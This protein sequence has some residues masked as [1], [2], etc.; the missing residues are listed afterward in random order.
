VAKADIIIVGLHKAPN[1]PPRIYLC[2]NIL[3]GAFGGG[4]GRELGPLNPED[5]LPDEKPG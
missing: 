2:L 3:D 1:D 4:E 5:G